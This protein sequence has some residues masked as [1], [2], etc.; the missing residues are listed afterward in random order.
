MV[1]TAKERVR[2]VMVGG[3]RSR[4]IVLDVRLDDVREEL[5]FGTP[6]ILSL[7]AMTIVFLKPQCRLDL[8]SLKEIVP[9]PIVVSANQAFQNQGRFE[10]GDF[11]P[12]AASADGAEPCI[13]HCNTLL[14]AV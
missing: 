13:G 10:P 2:I 6:N 8:I 14:T 11:C 5:S 1:M 7:Y 12:I 9:G 4:G 3:F